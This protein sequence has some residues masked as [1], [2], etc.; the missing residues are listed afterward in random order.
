MSSSERVSDL[1][2]VVRNAVSR[3]GHVAGNPVTVDDVDFQS[4]LSTTRSSLRRATGI[5]GS[6]S[7]RSLPP[8]YRHH[9]SA[10]H[11]PVR[12]RTA[13]VRPPDMCV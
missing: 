8:A 13:A 7:H 3:A 10:L 6:L 4:V 9:I 2:N 12:R 11:P 1:V 5:V